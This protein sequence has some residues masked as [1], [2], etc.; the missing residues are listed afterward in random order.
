MMSDLL[1]LPVLCCIFA[2]LLTYNLVLYYTLCY[3]I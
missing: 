3:N 2:P 1:K